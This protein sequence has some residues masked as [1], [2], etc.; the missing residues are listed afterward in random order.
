MFE[1]VLTS[2]ILIGESPPEYRSM[3]MPDTSLLD[4]PVSGL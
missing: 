1:E 2:Q 4:G 3:T